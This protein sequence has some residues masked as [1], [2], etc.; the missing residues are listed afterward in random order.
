MNFIQA[1]SVAEAMR[2]L[3]K[4][5][6]R[7]LAGG[8]DLSV[9]Y[10]RTL[11]DWDGLLHIGRIPE[12]RKIEICERHIE[13]GA[14]VT[15]AEIARHGNDDPGFSVLRDA[16]QTIGSPGIMNCGTLGGNLATASPAGDGSLAL[17]ALDAIVSLASESGCRDIPIGEF[18]VGPRKSLLKPDEMIVSLRFGRAR[19]GERGTAFRKIGNRDA[20]ILSVASVAVSVDV[21]REGFC[22]SARV[23]FGA[24]A[25]TP[26]RSLSVEAELVGKKLNASQSLNLLASIR[27]D[28]SPI[29]DQRSTAWYRQE[30]LPV[31]LRD[32]VADAGNRIERDS[33]RG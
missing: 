4:G 8:T 24:V 22:R 26:R 14:A 32:A 19:R 30:V 27:T 20:S 11:P 16:A 18:L 31:L 17:L 25:P 33:G 7:L 2:W 9:E 10:R 29:D 12:L 28:V 6:L 15:Y 23:A 3:A 1:E 21:D 13:I 5:Q